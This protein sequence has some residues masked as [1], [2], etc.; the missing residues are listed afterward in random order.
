MSRIVSIAILRV[1]PESAPVRHD[2]LAYLSNIRPPRQR[3]SAPGRGR[4]T[5]LAMTDARRSRR[6][7]FLSQ[8]VCV[9]AALGPG[10]IA[11]G[12]PS[13]DRRPIESTVADDTAAG[14]AALSHAPQIEK[15]TIDRLLDGE[16]WPRR[17][18]A[19]MRLERYACLESRHILQTLL[20]DEAW[21]VRAFAVRTLG[22]RRV[23]AT[24]VS[25]A[26]E[27]EPR[28]LRTALRH[29]YPLDAERLGRGIRYLARAR[30]LQDKMLA[31]ELA[32][33]SGDEELSAFAKETVKKIILRM[34][35]IDAGL[36]SPRLAVVTGQP[37]MR[38]R[39]RWQKWLRKTGR[40]FALRPAHSI[41][42]SPH[43]PIEPG[44]F[45]TLEPNDFAALESYIESLSSRSL[46]L[47]ICL[48]CTA[49]MWSELAE[50]QGGIDDLMVFVG[51]VVQTLRVALI[52]YRDRRDEFETRAW[53]FTSDITLARQ[54]LWSLT[55]GGGGDRPEAVYPAMQL[56]CSRLSW[57]PGN[58]K[59]LV[60]IGDAPPRVG[61][62]ALCARLARRG[63]QAQL[64]THVIQ[65][66]GKEVKHFREIAKAG[67]GRCLSLADGDS[68]IVEIAGLTLGERFQDELR[69]FFVTYLELCR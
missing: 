24:E 5:L 30:S 6:A 38:R 19:A 18:I 42:E 50:A 54:R 1:K 67:G 40:R 34:T 65:A 3:T 11:N 59:V 58:T 43:T 66:E 33:A 60:L 8:V 29:R 46:D 51:D 48:D 63:A 57:Q 53:D 2:F 47:A 22:R 69:E 12:E 45:V 4:P 52:A 28:V 21:Q 16:S 26:T 56:A 61:T 41:P 49:S 7:A 64:T 17:A 36:L 9:A 27:H 37:N 15:Q 14:Q 44:L 39:Y 13:A 32:I 62:G 68:L 55:A 35:R 23:P 31:V 10:G 25:F 20:T